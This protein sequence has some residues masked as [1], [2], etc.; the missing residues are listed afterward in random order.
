MCTWN[1]TWPAHFFMF[2]PIAFA[3][4]HCQTGMTFV[5][6]I[7]TLFEIFQFQYFSTRRKRCC[8]WQQRFGNHRGIV[9]CRCHSMII[10]IITK[11]RIRKKQASRKQGQKLQ[12][13][14][15]PQKADWSH[16]TLPLQGGVCVGNKDHLFVAEARVHQ[17]YQIM[18]RAQKMSG[19][20]E[21]LLLRHSYGYFWM[22]FIATHWLSSTLFTTLWNECLKQP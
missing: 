3:W 19:R 9:L 5:T 11:A 21:A 20:I 8:T 2:V 17:K 12:G 16:S 14:A 10:S 6:V 22:L 7:N 4:S 1:K 15:D 18:W 13:Q